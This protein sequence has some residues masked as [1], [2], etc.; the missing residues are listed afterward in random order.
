MRN[1]VGD[2]NG[3]EGGGGGGEEDNGGFKKSKGSDK[4]S[5]SRE[6]LL[7]RASR[8]IKKKLST[9]GAGGG[10]IGREKKGTGRTEQQDDGALPSSSSGTTREGRDPSPTHG[11]KDRRE[12][13][14]F[15]SYYGE[16]RGGRSETSRQHEW[17]HFQQR[18]DGR[19]EAKDALLTLPPLDTHFDDVGG[20][21]E[22]D[23]SS[24]S[25]HDASTLTTNFTQ[26]FSYGE[27][28]GA[29]GGESHPSASSCPL[30]ERVEKYL[31][32]PPTVVPNDEE[33]GRGGF[34][35]DSSGGYHGRDSSL[36]FPQNTVLSLPRHPELQKSP[37]H[38]QQQPCLQGSQHLSSMSSSTSRD[39]MGHFF[40]S[41]DTEQCLAS[42]QAM[43]DKEEEL[44]VLEDALAR[45][46]KEQEQNEQLQAEDSSQNHVM[47]MHDITA[48]DNDDDGYTTTDNGPKF[49]AK[50]S[51]SSHSMKYSPALSSKHNIEGEKNDDPIFLELQRMKEKLIEQEEEMSGKVS[52]LERELRKHEKELSDMGVRDVKVRAYEAD[53]V[54][55]LTAELDAYKVECASHRNRILEMERKTA[56]LEKLLYEESQKTLSLESENQMLLTIADDNVTHSTDVDRARINE[57]TA[58]KEQ[59]DKYR[60]RVLE[61]TRD[62]L[63]K[64]EA[65]EAT[66]KLAFEHEE[67]KKSL[68]AQLEKMNSSN[69]SHEA[70]NESFRKKLENEE[71]KTKSLE[72]E[73]STLK[74]QCS[75]AQA[76]VADAKHKADEYKRLMSILESENATLLQ[77]FND[78]KESLE[79]LQ[80]IAN[81]CNQIE[82]E[83]A[84]LR[85]RN[86]EISAKQIDTSKEVYDARS[87]ASNITRLQKIICDN[88][89][90]ISKL[91]DD[92]SNAR[93]LQL[94][95]LQNTRQ[96]FLEEINTLTEN[97]K[98]EKK[99]RREAEIKSNEL[100][101]KLLS[102]ERERF[103]LQN[104][105]THRT[106]AQDDQILK[107]MQH[108]DDLRKKNIEC[109]EDYA[110]LERAMSEKS[111][112]D[113]NI[114][115]ELQSKLALLDKENSKMSD[116]LANVNTELSLARES[117]MKEVDDLI[118][119]IREKDCALLTLK[120][121]I[122]DID[123]V[124]ANDIERLTGII[125]LREKDLEDA[126]SSSKSLRKQL[127]KIKQHSLDVINSTRIEKMT[128]LSD[129]QNL[130]L[131]E[132]VALM[133]QAKEMACDYGRK[134]ES[135]K[136]EHSMSHAVAM[137]A[138]HAQ[139]REIEYLLRT[140]TEKTAGLEK[141]LE[142]MRIENQ[143]LVDMLDSA[144]V[145][146]SAKN[147][148]SLVD[149]IDEI[150]L[151]RSDKAIQIRTLEVDLKSLA[152][153]NAHLEYEKDSLF[154]QLDDQERKVREVESELGRLRDALRVQ[155]EE[156][157]SLEKKLDESR[158]ESE[159]VQDQMRKAFDNDRR[160]QDKF[161]EEIIA[162]K[163][164]ALLCQQ[165]LKTKLN[166]LTEEITARDSQLLELQ[167]DVEKSRQERDDICAKYEDS[168][169]HIASL[170][171]KSLNSKDHAN[172]LMT[173]YM[174]IED[175][176]RRQLQFVQ[177][178]KEGLER[179]LAVVERE[180]DRL[181]GDFCREKNALVSTLELKEDSVLKLEEQIQELIKSKQES[182]EQINELNKKV[183]YLKLGSTKLNE[184][185][186]AVCSE[187][188]QL[189]KNAEGLISSLENSVSMKNST[190][191]ELNSTIVDIVDT[192]Q[193]HVDTMETLQERVNQITADR[194]H[195]T[196]TVHVLESYHETNDVTIKE[197][198]KTLEE[199]RLKHNEKLGALRG[200]IARFA[201]E[202]DA[203][204]QEIKD[205]KFK[206][207]ELDSNYECE[208]QMMKLSIEAEKLVHDNEVAELQS[209]FDSELEH[210]QN[211]ARELMEAAKKQHETISEQDLKIEQL[212]AA[213]KKS[214]EEALQ[215]G[216]K[217]TSDQA[218]LSEIT[219]T[220]SSFQEENLKLKQSLEQS[221]CEVDGI[222]TELSS[223][224]LEQSDL[225]LTLEK[226]I[227]E[228]QRLE[229]DLS[230]KETI[231]IRTMNT[232][233][234][235]Q[236]KLARAQQE[237]DA[238]SKAADAEISRLK[239][240]LSLLE[241]TQQE[242]EK[243]L[244]RKLA[245]AEQER[246]AQSEY[247]DAEITR[248]KMDLSSLEKLQQ[249]KEKHLMNQIVAL[250]EDSKVD[251]CN[252]HL[253]RELLSKLDDRENYYNARIN[254]MAPTIDILKEEIKSL[255]EEND[256]LSRVNEGIIA[257]YEA[258]VEEKN[259]L[260]LA[261]ET[262]LF[263][264][265]GL[266]EST[267]LSSKE[268]DGS[269]T[270]SGVSRAYHLNRTASELE[271]T[272]QAIKKHHSDTV[273]RLQGE[274]GDARVRLNKYQR[275]VKEL[276]GLIE[277]NSFVIESL[278]RKLQG[279]KCAQYCEGISPRPT[280]SRG[281]AGI[282]NSLFSE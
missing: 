247:A 261:N 241:K 211:R 270:K 127:Y 225:K 196:R 159:C 134:V 3:E 190:I 266:S 64:E 234:H 210:H 175:G 53:Y 56:N 96:K 273:K 78:S 199:E 124:K 49:F 63:A 92:L 83:N 274:L 88:E 22:A 43:Q 106:K 208:I 236:L 230:D 79:K 65:L 177:G 258:L 155:I 44:K 140:E 251:N 194:D 110:T 34:C 167:A 38:E 102:M 54:S 240:D 68:L 192:R 25:T 126:K 86:D 206:M 188:D 28:C 268:G 26:L 94:E 217:I 262:M 264:N 82:E 250:K 228:K 95:S 254:S 50:K 191:A 128:L 164:E 103:N 40:L 77:K 259:M 169:E 152:S 135:H 122:S 137:S 154:T 17:H 133:K 51:N 67:E 147:M 111:Q 271:T 42:G 205:W 180:S 139:K 214:L 98:I 156:N 29:G 163:E 20:S 187:R 107:L 76:D 223:Q 202:N 105:S 157:K 148:D 99:S 81:R 12:A 171:D 71:S 2:D 231:M 184:K 263:E 13:G 145:K 113:E 246:Y 93:A 18:G 170:L 218:K 235:L 19:R 232:L 125:Q 84:L 158:K 215:L 142:K 112:A 197:L 189:Y 278:H 24:E 182:Q 87:L 100:E 168:R 237:R 212:Q 45:S 244:V 281:S 267:K 221:Q 216:S 131:N 101:D 245:R 104:D 280:S 55:Q 8:K 23:D 11:V 151:D 229:S 257:D 117:K 209:V 146:L 57:L 185:Y 179:R 256:R 275:K 242:Q 121:D 203:L 141:S 239:H 201:A 46:R 200:D 144:C 39:M 149:A 75:A 108:A 143:A 59:C 160:S 74:S 253:Y 219:H 220:V 153:N 132:R 248:L 118:Q 129:V 48:N 213:L 252:D 173:H 114:I 37:V 238:H 260:A 162:E 138:I 195:L 198:T 5:S 69:I 1:D 36:S 136:L 72:A 15:Y 41:K 130:I 255:T 272:I 249:E 16:G 66:G 109:R 97:L 279:K 80:V 89:C 62:A 91:Q 243:S 14:D 207:A 120:S 233:T 115:K 181:M 165:D 193:K 277:E 33:D 276:T 226:T 70:T 166:A 123:A 224:E 35:G 150:L 119:I 47:L 52:V 176:L 6:G 73:L 61:L 282:D 4:S 10:R 116:D 60:Q 30:R 227:S 178:E 183:K 174:E 32:T 27:E 269:S 21:G 85:K 7:S 204:S 90:Y 186:E 31:A 265:S 9:V 58:Y 222:V 172:N 161:A